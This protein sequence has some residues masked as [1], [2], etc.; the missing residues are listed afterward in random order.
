MT[1]SKHVIERDTSGYNDR[2]YGK[3]YIAVVDL[4]N[5][6][7]SPRWGAWIGH[8]GEPGVLSIEANSGD[9]VMMGQKDFRKPRN[10]S[11]EYYAVRDD[12]SLSESMTKADAYKQQ[13]DE[14]RTK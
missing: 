9:V 6:D 5:K 11:P 7:A 8:P 1:K 14:G 4:T 12:G 3:P 2:R 13:R 10:S